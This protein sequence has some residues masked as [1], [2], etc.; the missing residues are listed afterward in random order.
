MDLFLPDSRRP[1]TWWSAARSVFGL[2]DTGAGAPV[3][4]SGTLPHAEVPL[5]QQA[6]LPVGVALL[7][8]AVDEVLVLLLLVGAGLG[9]EADDGQQ[10]FRV[11][12]HLLLDHR[13]QLLVAGPHRVLAGVVG[14]CP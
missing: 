13:A 3:S 7:D 6:H 4:S 1:M 14:P 12:E 11:R 10:V 8:H 2:E 5:T 9:V